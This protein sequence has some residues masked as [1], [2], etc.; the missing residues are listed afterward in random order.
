MKEIILFIMTF[1]LVYIFYQVFIIKKSKRRNSKKRPAEVNFLI[2]KYNID[3]KKLDYKKLLNVVAITSSLDISLMVSIVSII[4]SVLIQIVLALVLV[5]PIFLLS[6]Y[7][8]A[9]YYI[10]KGYV[11]NV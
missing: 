3:I 7:I 2:Y 1:L 6:Y 8:V 10:K 5:I 9:K 11:K 4:K